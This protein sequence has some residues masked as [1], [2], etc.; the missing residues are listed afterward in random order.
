[1]NNDML[2]NEDYMDCSSTQ[3][4]QV[5]ALRSFYAQ[6]SE[7]E[8]VDSVFMGDEPLS[9]AVPVEDTDAVVRWLRD[10]KVWIAFKPYIKEEDGKVVLVLR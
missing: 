9:V 7:L 6:E 10:A 5:A 1:M 2:Y 3:D 4:V 8:V